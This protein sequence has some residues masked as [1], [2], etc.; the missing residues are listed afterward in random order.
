MADYSMEDE[1]W[2]KNKSKIQAYMETH[3]LGDMAAVINWN[4]TQGDNDKDNRKRFWSS[5]TTL[6]GMLDDS[7]IS[8]GRES[9]LPDEV[10]NLINTYCAIFAQAHAALFATDP[11]FGELIR[12]HGKSG[13]GVYEDADEYA[14]GQSKSMRMKLTRYY[15][16]HLKGI[17]NEP[18][19]DGTSVNDV[20]TINSPIQSE[21][22]EEE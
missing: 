4:L 2:N 1:K 3:D 13:G 16:N 20:P 8:R 15:R 5:I 9:N 19:W 6:F 14:A 11:L 12:K 18:T 22:E 10:Q 17:T 7:P 21:A